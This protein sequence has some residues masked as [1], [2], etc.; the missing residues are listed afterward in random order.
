MTQ[1]T[2]GDS[3]TE[4]QG[5]DRDDQ[6]DDDDDDEV[7]LLAANER[8]TCPLTLLPFQHPV[9]S[10]MCPHSF[11]K[12]AISDLIR[13]SSEHVP[14]TEEQEAE[15]RRHGR[16]QD[17]R[18]AEEKLRRTLPKLARCPEAGCEARL[19]LSDLYDD[20]ALLRRTKRRLEAQRRQAEQD[21]DSDEEDPDLPRGTQ[22][23]R[24]VALGSSPTSSRRTTLIKG[25]IMST[26]PNS[27]QQPGIDDVDDG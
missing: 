14:F 22:R 8:I 26:I 27:Q 25:E 6:D 23:R 1:N 7:D 10:N 16:A 18:K 5:A 19:R 2:L 21:D 3:D 9:S 15:L 11:E 12:S 20:P 13:A 4:M 24:V 17:R